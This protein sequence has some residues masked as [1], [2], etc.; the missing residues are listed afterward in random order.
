MLRTV[1]NSYHHELSPVINDVACLMARFKCLVIKH[2]PR[3]N[4]KVAHCLA[5]YALIMVVGH[6]M[7]LNPPSFTRV[8]SQGDIE[9]LDT[10]WCSG[11]ARGTCNDKF[12][13]NLF[14]NNLFPGG[15]NPDYV[16]DH[17]N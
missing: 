6:K 9:R 15:N 3:V 10:R 13:S 5:Q 11:E 14:Y 1:D 4:N 17:S 7:F 8:A 16:R 2:G 12:G